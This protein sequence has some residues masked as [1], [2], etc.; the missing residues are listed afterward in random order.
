MSSA[1]ARDI[2]KEA[3]VDDL[4]CYC[5]RYSIEDIQRDCLNNGM[6]TI[7]EKIKMEKSFGNCQCSTKNPKGK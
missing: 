1:A 2:F 3:L 6:S 4:I 5:F 7:V